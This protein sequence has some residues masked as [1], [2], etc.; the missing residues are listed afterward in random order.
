[1]SGSAKRRSAERRAQDPIDVA[2]RGNRRVDAVGGGGMQLARRPVIGSRESVG[3]ASR[4]ARAQPARDPATSLLR[5]NSSDRRRA[6]R[7]APCPPSAVFSCSRTICG[8]GASGLTWSGVTG[9][10]PP[11]SFSPAAMR[12]GYAPGVRFGGACRFICGPKIKRASASVHISSSSSGSAASRHLRCRLGAEVLHDDF[13][14]V[15]VRLVQLANCEQRI[16]ALSARLADADQDAGSERYFELSRRAQRGEA[17]RGRLV[18]RAV[19][20]AAAF[21]Q[22]LGDCSPA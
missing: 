15:A 19:V 22:A 11:Q 9:D 12:C 14:D 7:P 20:H 10:T 18:G 13:L 8:Q 2:A 1:M 5:G 6:A 4:A 17:Q 3:I 21:A 16:D